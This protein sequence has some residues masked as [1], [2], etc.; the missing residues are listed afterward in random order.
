MTH[1]KLGFAARSHHC[2]AARIGSDL[3]NIACA[4]AAW[5]KSN[6]HVFPNDLAASFQWSCSLARTQTTAREMFMVVSGSVAAMIQRFAHVCF[7]KLGSICISGGVTL[8]MN[9]GRRV[10]DLNRHTLSLSNTHSV[11]KSATIGGFD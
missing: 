4:K 3:F 6:R 11:I 10:C 1:P 7:R 2:D 5:S 9:T 8:L